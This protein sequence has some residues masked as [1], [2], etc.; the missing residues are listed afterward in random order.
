MGKSQHVAGRYFSNAKIQ[1]V[2]AFTIGTELAGN[3]SLDAA[4]VKRG[5][6]SHFPVVH[7]RFG[8][9]FLYIYPNYPEA[10]V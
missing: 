9:A 6:W 3:G 1:H 10:V 4:A 7:K 2:Q 8:G 5:G